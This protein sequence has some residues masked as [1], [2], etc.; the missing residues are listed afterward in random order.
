MR[1]I[2]EG[3]VYH[4]IQRGNNFEPIFVED[5]DR[6]LFLRLLKEAKGKFFLNVYSFCLMDNHIHILLKISSSNLSSAM[7]W[8]F[9]SYAKK[10][11][12]KYKRKGHLFTSRYRS[13]VCLNDSY[14]LH[15]SRYIHLNPIKAGLAA[16]PF[17]YRWSSCGLFNRSG[18]EINSFV[19]T[20]FVLSLFGEN[21]DESAER[22]GIFIKE[23]IES[24]SGF[25]YPPIIV[26]NVI[27]NLEDLFKI[28]DKPM[29]DNLL[30]NTGFTDIDKRR[31]RRDRY[32]EYI[33]F[34]MKN[35]RR[36]I[37]A[38]DYLIFQR[39]KSGEE[40]EA[41]AGSMKVSPRTVS[42]ACRKVELWK[43]SFSPK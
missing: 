39:R 34:L 23:G 35:K 2:Y 18:K 20:D 38:R 28:R 10:I 19:D 12:D 3:A 15:L 43:K 1:I 8:L 16:D 42:R 41:I 27:G 25:E 5:K 33:G 7:H 24:G 31:L 4:I 36:N 29:F 26:K 17:R 9:M 14:F 40:V 32:E 11:T 37:A 21:R 6:L 13:L 22:H 30:G